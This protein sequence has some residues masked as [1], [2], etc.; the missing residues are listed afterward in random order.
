MMN[1]FFYACG[2]ICIILGL[3]CLVSERFLKVSLRSTSFG[4]FFN[5]KIGKSMGLV[6]VRL[7]Y[8]LA[9]VLFGIGFL[10]LG[11]FGPPKFPRL[12][13]TQPAPITSPLSR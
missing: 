4:T 2:A 10:Y 9:Q 1:I 11:Y 6:A 7:V 5:Q 3:A 13:S 8:G 12:F